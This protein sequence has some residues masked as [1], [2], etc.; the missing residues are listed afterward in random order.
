[1]GGFLVFTYPEALWDGEGRGGER[2]DI[3]AGSVEYFAGED[4]F[5]CVGL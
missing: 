2:W 3:L 4:W 5:C 1:M